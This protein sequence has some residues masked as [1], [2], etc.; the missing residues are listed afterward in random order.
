HRV[1][2]RSDRVPRPGSVRAR[3]LRGAGQIGLPSDG[4]AHG[5]TDLTERQNPGSQGIVLGVE[6]GGW[7]TEHPGKPCSRPHVRH[8]L[9]SLVLIDPGTGG[10]SIY[11]GPDSQLLLRDAG[12]QASLPQAL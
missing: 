8:V 12:A 9:S 7:N 1:S 4:S 5:C 10:K 3:V 11:P 6:I 2:D